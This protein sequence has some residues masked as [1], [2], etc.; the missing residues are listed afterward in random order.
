MITIDKG[1]PS[2][3]H[4]D[5]KA[6]AVIRTDR[7]L[8]E[9][10]LT[11]RG[12]RD[13]LDAA[14]ARSS[15][16]ATRELAVLSR[17]LFAA[18]GMQGGA[19]WLTG[20]V[21]ILDGNTF[22]V[23]DQ[24]GDIEASPTDTVGPVLVRHPVP[25]DL[26]AHRRTASGSTRSPSTTC[27]YFESRFF[28][29]PG[30]GTVYVN[31]TLSVIRQRSVGGGFHEAADRAQPR[32]RAGRPD[33]PHR[34][35]LRLRRPVRGQGRHRRRRASTTTG[36]TTAPAA[37]LPAGDVPAGDHDLVHARRAQ[38]DESGLTFDLRIGAA[39]SSGRTDL[40]RRHARSAEER[41]PSRRSTP[42]RRQPR[43]DLAAATSRSGWPARRRCSSRPGRR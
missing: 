15:S 11:G 30:T 34:R 4:R 12:Q 38:V 5:G 16:R 20:T 24:R 17:R 18:T 36:S 39:R 41:A 37:R 3:A 43:P 10:I 32:R 14:R 33:R 28:L 13:G 25:V 22:V 6:D 8:F 27:N 31:A 35:R 21:S 29:V 1:D 42:R 19:R 40:D 9:R 2:V 23:S 7:K 26:G